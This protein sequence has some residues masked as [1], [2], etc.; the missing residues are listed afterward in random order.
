VSSFGAALEVNRGKNFA[1]LR[2]MYYSLVLATW[3]KRKFQES[4]YKSYI[5]QQKI[6]GIDLADKSAKDRIYALYC[7]AFKKGVYD[8]V[9]TARTAKNYP[10]SLL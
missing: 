8:Y 10:A 6:A 5:N 9:G 4:F 1:Q 7:E 2:Q 3:F